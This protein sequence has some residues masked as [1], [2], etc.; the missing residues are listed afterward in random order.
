[1]RS[2]RVTG[3]RRRAGLGRGREERGTDGQ[4]ERDMRDV[5]PPGVLAADVV[6]SGGHSITTQ[7]RALLRSIRERV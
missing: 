2:R 7:W 1:M 5:R 6:R 3:R 4:G